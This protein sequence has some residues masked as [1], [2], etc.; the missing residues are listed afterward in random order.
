[1]NIIYKWIHRVWYENAISGIILVPISG[2]YF[3]LIKIKEF[4]YRYNFLSSNKLE[5]PVIVIGNITAGGTG[6]TPLVIWLANELKNRGHVPGVISR[7]YGGSK[8]NLSTIVDS[9]SDPGI[10]GDE[11]ILIA[12]RSKCPV[13]V[14]SNRVRASMMLIE[15]GVDVI[16]SDDG[17]Q[18]SQLQRDFEI[19]VVDGSL[20]FG[21]HRLI[22][23]GPL[24]E[25]P[26]RL[27]KVDQILVNGKNTFQSG[28]SFELLA[29]KA[30]RLNGTLCKTLTSFKGKTVH[31]VAGI[32]N[33]KR[34]FELLKTFGIKVI[35][36]SFPDH[37]VFNAKDL[38]F[39]DQLEIFMTEKDAI[40]I[41]KNTSDKFWFIPVEV[42]MKQS[43]SADLIQNIELCL[44]NFGKK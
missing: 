26:S 10:V 6:K 25:L 43:T 5:V 35:E 44:G 29:L 12:T 21:N 28:K 42:S 33:P 3:I 39:D 30:N 38:N 37:A 9:K 20:G 7:G 36:H 13:V 8:V 19:C 41:D 17:L 22:P 27:K 4:L 14:D 18:H 1:M 24:R 2:I 40:K 23:S 34:F 15:K 31:A 11:P 16:I 32:G